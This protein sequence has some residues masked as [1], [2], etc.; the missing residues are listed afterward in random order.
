[1]PRAFEHF[2]RLLPAVR[3]NE[4]SRALFFIALLTLVTAAQTAGL[5]GSEALFLAKLSALQLPL[6]FLF[7]A[8][9]AMVGSGI[10]AA[11]VGAARNDVMFAVMLLGAG[12]SLL[13]FGIAV[14]E[15]GRFALFGL[16]AVYYLTQGVLINHFWTF[17]GDYFDTLT[18][19][20]L[21]PVFALG[22]SAGGLIGGVLG[23]LTA[24]ELGPLETIAAWGA[25]LCAAA[26]L[27]LIA[28]RPLRRWGASGG[29]EY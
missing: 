6:A 15:P 9:A 29:A 20:R 22:S 12:L 21:V 1:M 14:P 5:A 18:S 10:Y 27:L 19:K 4:R 28:R 11:L 23:A 26:A 13:G 24:Q 16:I 17:A 2:W 7:A 25:L 3:R 8:V